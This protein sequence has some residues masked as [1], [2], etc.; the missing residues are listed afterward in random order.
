MSAKLIS[1]E[2]VRDGHT[3]LIDVP[4]HLLAPSL[5]GHDVI[6]FDNQGEEVTLTEE[7]VDAFLAEERI[8]RQYAMEEETRR[9]V[10]M[11]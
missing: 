3:V 1:M 5:D 6:G 9:T 2:V 7:E 8:G 4:E 11:V 10:G